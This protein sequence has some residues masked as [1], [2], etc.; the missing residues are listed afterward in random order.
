MCTTGLQ[1]ANLGVP[2]DLTPLS[3]G[4][5]P[6]GWEGKDKEEKCTFCKFQ[7]KASGEG[8]W[9]QWASCGF[10]SSTRLSL[11]LARK[12]ETGAVQSIVALRVLVTLLTVLFSGFKLTLVTGLQLKS[13][14]E[15]INSLQFLYNLSILT[16]PCRLFKFHNWL[17][18]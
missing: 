9:N 12:C 13:L 16:S 5:P 11:P 3:Y 14:I 6:A 4:S 15:F 1:P 10:H 8:S 2:G 17:P 7:W 18:T